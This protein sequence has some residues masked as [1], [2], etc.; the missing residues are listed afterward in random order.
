MAAGLLAAAVPG[1]P[2]LY[3]APAMVRDLLGAVGVTAPDA[4]LIGARL[5]R[6]PMLMHTSAVHLGARNAPDAPG[7]PRS[8]SLQPGPQPAA[9]WT[10]AVLFAAGTGLYA[11]RGAR[12]E[13]PGSR[14]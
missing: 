1:G 11:L 2:E 5:S 7:P 4:T 9:W 8:W 12:A 10:A 14:G 13:G 3:G 6:L